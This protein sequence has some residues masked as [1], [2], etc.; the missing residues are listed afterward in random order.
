M[1]SRCDWYDRIRGVV[2]S[3]E[4]CGRD[5]DGYTLALAAPP[6]FSMME[7]EDVILSAARAIRL[8][9]QAGGMTAADLV[10]FTRSLFERIAEQYDAEGDQ[11]DPPD[12]PSRA[13]GQGEA[14][15]ADGGGAAVG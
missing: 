14:R 2:V 4:I 13:A 15:S 10:K 1:C 8:N 12:G 11:D 6:G 5:K 9:R 7:A 3:V